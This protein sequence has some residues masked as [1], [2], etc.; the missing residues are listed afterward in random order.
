MERRE[1]DEKSG[2]ER[3]EEIERREEEGG[4]ERRVR[5]ATPSCVES[6]QVFLGLEGADVGKLPP[7]DLLKSLSGPDNH[8]SFLDLQQ[9]GPGIWEHGD[10]P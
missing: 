6:E 5:S 3:R 10:N 2:G 4:G 8:L 9:A 1:E 7:D